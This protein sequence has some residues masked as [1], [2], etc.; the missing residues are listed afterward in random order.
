MGHANGPAAAL[1]LLIHAQEVKGGGGR[2]G[3]GG[4]LSAKQL[5]SSAAVSTAHT[6]NEIEMPLAKRPSGR[7]GGGAAQKVTTCPY[8]ELFVTHGTTTA[9]LLH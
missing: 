4:G 3:R 6:G 1:H 2:G 8:V 5:L 9:W 7:G